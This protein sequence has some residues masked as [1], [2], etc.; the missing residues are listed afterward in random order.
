MRRPLLLECRLFGQLVESR[1]H[2]QLSSVHPPSAAWSTNLSAT[3]CSSS[4]A[5]VPLFNHGVLRLQACSHQQDCRPAPPLSGDES[6]ARQNL[7]L[8][9]MPNRGVSTKGNEGVLLT[10]GLKSLF[11]RVDRHDNAF[12]HKFRESISSSPCPLP[13]SESKAGVI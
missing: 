5:D 1:P 3:R 12:H 2:W 7:L 4:Q 8:E 11:V 13:K 10:A 9:R 6:R